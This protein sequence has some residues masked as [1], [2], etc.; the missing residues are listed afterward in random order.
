MYCVQIKTSDQST[1]IT[2]LSDKRCVDYQSVALGQSREH[3]PL[4]EGSLYGGSPVQVTRLDLT[5][6]D[7]VR[8]LGGLQL[9]PNL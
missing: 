9:S 4:A 7:N 6:K 3:S 5:K 2:Y 1:R 8:L